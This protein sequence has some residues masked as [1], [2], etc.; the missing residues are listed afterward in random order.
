ML[1]SCAVGFSDI[2]IPAALSSG[3]TT[4]PEYGKFW[5]VTVPP[6]PFTGAAP[7]RM[8]VERGGLWKAGIGG[9]DCAEGGGAVVGFVDSEGFDGNLGNPSPNFSSG[10]LVKGELA[11]GM[12]SNNPD[13]VPLRSAD[14]TVGILFCWVC[15]GSDASVCDPFPSNTLPLRPFLFGTDA[16]TSSC[17]LSVGIDSSGMSSF[18]SAMALELVGSSN[19]STVG[20]LLDTPAGVDLSFGSTAT[21]PDLSWGILCS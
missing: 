5:L 21:F 1:G 18:F 6:L 10:V 14:V 3:S 9:S 7:F 16:V 17:F 12:P 4:V 11:E 8:F 20:K 15:G 19:M 13:R 2:I